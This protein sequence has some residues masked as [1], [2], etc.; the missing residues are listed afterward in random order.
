MIRFL[1]REWRTAFACVMVLKSASQP[2]D[3]RSA[4]P[5]WP[6]SQSR[7]GPPFIRRAPALN[8]DRFIVSPR[9][10]AQGQ[11]EEILAQSGPIFQEQ[12]SPR[13]AL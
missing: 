7:G 3:R 11:N 1:A 13:T 2:A 6:T 9:S 4:L 12:V 5:L 8:F 10:Q